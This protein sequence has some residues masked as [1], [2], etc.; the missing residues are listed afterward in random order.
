[1][2]YNYS[3]EIIITNSAK[4]TEYKSLSDTELLQKVS[5]SDSKALE[6]LYERYS[7]LLFTLIKKIVQK[8][9]AAEHLL[10]E[11]FVIIWRK[12]NH[13]NFQSGN[14][15]TWIVTLTRN[16][17]I[18]CLQRQ[19]ANIELEEY[20]DAYEDQFIIPKL[21]AGADA[22]D[23]NTAF[24]IR[25]NIENALSK[26][27]DAQKYVIHLAYYEGYTQKG[28]AEKLNIPLQ[29]VK[30]KVKFALNNF[31]DNLIKESE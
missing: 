4:L 23:L 3:F 21:A 19:R 27:T 29:T 7:P 16:K 13:F 12:V 17:A 9:E 2:V 15:Y 8:Q 30:T 11:V 18:D 28:I 25:S 20:N 5:N 22:L 31:K 10:T 1:M 6:M 24:S 14:A 26:L